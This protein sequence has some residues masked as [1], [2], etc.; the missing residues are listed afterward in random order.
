MKKILKLGIISAVVV[1]TVGMIFSRILQI[2]F[3]T[4][5]LEYQNSSLFRPWSDP[6]MSVYF[7]YPFILGIILAWVWLKT[8]S[9]LEGK[10]NLE[11]GIYFGVVYW[12]IASIP[13]MVITYSSFQV[14][15]LM[16]LSWS[17]GGLIQAISAGLIFSHLDK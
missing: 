7:V 15:F 10:N 4:M 12:I 13:G 11:K 16:V 6:L 1:L 2:I 17:L 14:S 5:A 8:K 9:L 3:S